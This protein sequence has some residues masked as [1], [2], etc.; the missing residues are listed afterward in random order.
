MKKLIALLAAAV[1]LSS[2]AVAQVIS[3]PLSPGESLDVTCPTEL[4]GRIQ[5]QSAHLNCAPEPTPSPTPDPKRFTEATGTEAD[6]QG[7]FRV[8]C[9]FTH[10]LQV[11]PVVS[12]GAQSAHMHDFVGNPSTNANSTYDSMVAATTNCTNGGDTA[13][14]WAPTL[15]SPSG[16]PVAPERA[17]FYYRN[18]PIGYRVT[19]TP[20][21]DFRLIAGGDGTFPIAYWTC[22]GE[23]DG[24]YSTSKSSIPNCGSAKIKMHVYFPS[25]ADGRF[26][27]PNH[28][29]HVVYGRDNGVTETRFPETCPASHPIKITQL[30]FRY[31][32]PV[33][34]GTGY[35][36]SSG[37]TLPHADFW[38]TWNQA[39]FDSLVG[40]CLR[41]PR[42]C[43]APS[44]RVVSRQEVEIHHRHP[45]L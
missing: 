22:N 14:Y 8:E 27:S 21:P 29:S 41:Q 37:E 3:R 40:R 44:G 42:S 13:G 4:S 10:R 11:D 39:T 38:N 25:C 5:P 45:R 6:S 36:F 32:Y 28:R 31:L 2:V 33:T 35:R 12:P 19:T 7:S 20:P 1:L 34:N 24:S 17:I 43:D 9:K 30:D 15:I 16:Q 23:S 18:R 26:D